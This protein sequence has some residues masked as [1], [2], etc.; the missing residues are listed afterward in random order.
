MDDQKSVEMD[1]YSMG[2]TSGAAI[3][4]NSE[5]NREYLLHSMKM[6]KGKSST[7]TALRDK[8]RSNSP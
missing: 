2:V 5:H 6:D 7:Y 4:D 3:K 8:S 1:M